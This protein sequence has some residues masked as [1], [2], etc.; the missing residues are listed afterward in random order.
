MLRTHH[1]R[2]RVGA[3]PAASLATVL[4]ILHTSHPDQPPAE[5]ARAAESLSD[6]E[7]LRALVLSMSKEHALEL[8][9]YVLQQ[10]D[11]MHVRDQHVGHMYAKARIC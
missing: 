7:T 4:N 8:T 9:L 3:T 11:S 5:A 2:L 10:V 6:K 1:P